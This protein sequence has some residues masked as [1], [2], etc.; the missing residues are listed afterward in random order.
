MSRDGLRLPSSARPA[1]RGRH[2]GLQLATEVALGG[3]TAAAIIGMHRLF[4]D[5]SFFPPLFLQVVLAHLTVTLLRRAHCRLLPA[6]LITAVAALCAITWTHYLRTTTALLPTR[7]TLS[8]IDADIDA[9]WWLF[10]EVQAPAPVEV[11]FVVATSLAI[12]LIVFVA[13]WGAFRTGVSFEALLPPATLFLFAAVLG[14]EGSRAASAALFVAACLMFLLLHRIWR[15]E[16]TATWA[17]LHSQRGRRSLLSSGAVLAGVSVVVSGIAGP[18]MPGAEEPPLIPWKDLAEEDETRVV[19]SPLVDIRSR[20]VQQK[21]VEVFTVKTSDADFPGAFWRLTALDTYDGG[22]WRSSYATD[23][24]DGELPSSVEAD[25]DVTRVSQTITIQALGQVWLPA[26][27][28]PVAIDTHPAPSGRAPPTVGYESDSATLIVDQEAD[29]SDGLSYT[30]DSDVP[31]W[32]ADQLRQAPDQPFSDVGR[33]HLDLPDDFNP[34][35]TALA[36]QLTAPERTLY[37]K[38]L[39]LQRH[40]LGFAYTV[41]VQPG[42]SEDAMA[43]FLFENQAGYCEQFAGTFVAMARSVGIPARVVVGFTKG[44]QDHN[45]PTL[46]RVTGRQAHAWA[47]VYFDGFGWVIFDPTPGRAPPGADDW[48]GVTEQQDVPGDPTAPNTVPQ[49][50]PELAPNGGAQSPGEPTDTG[51]VAIGEPA[52]PIAPLDED[53][54]EGLVSRTVRNVGRPAGGLALAYLVVVPLA[55]VGA[56]WLRRLRARSSTDKVRLA[57]REIGE[58]AIQTG[59]RLPASLTVAERSSRM[60]AALPDAAAEVEVVARSVEQVNYAGSRPSARQADEAIRAATAVRTAAARRLSWYS[61]LLRHIDARRLLPQPER[62]RRSAH[63]AVRTA[64]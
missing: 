11:G 2:A 30:V 46:W 1:R 3:T 13:D 29:T 9:A 52:I 33:R 12:W 15:Q 32:S 20:L 50:A 34:D 63:G 48:L 21:D 5:G 41:D 35:I 28:E 40:L 57:W 37:D 60:R 59:L 62:S 24:A 47:E 44:I 39:A 56:R 4:E 16:D 36:E 6:G 17:A 61:R 64:P 10:R 54:S 27:F 25:T 18:R 8:S 43:D 51:E 26:A 45:E 7:A 55:L 19:V 58:E 38:A 31:T 53:D 49:D 42:H 14:A 22:I 23:E